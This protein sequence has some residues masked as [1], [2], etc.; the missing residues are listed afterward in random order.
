[1]QTLLTLVAPS[2]AED[3]F[4]RAWWFRF[5][6]SAM[7]AREVAEDIG[8]MAGVDIRQVLPTVRVPALILHRRDDRMADIR[9]SRYMAERIPGARFVD[10]PGEDELPFFGDQDAVLEE[11]EEFFTGVRPASPSDRVLATVLFTDIVGSTERAARLGDRAWRDLLEA[12]RSI[13]RR[14]LSRF[15]GREIETTGDGFLAT[16]DGPARA[17]RCAVAAAD[18]VHAMGLEIR[19]GLHAGEVE[20]VGDHVEGIAV[21]IGARIAALAGE[22]EVLVSQTVKDLVAGSGLSFE[23]AGTHNLKGVPGEWRVCRVVT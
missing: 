23:D 6:R 21:H 8:A 2:V 22:R 12:H 13:V 1:L 15:N 5:L 17:I 10:L 18:G 9:A 16:F 20:V 7:T 3:P 19:A 14:E 4:T 11:L